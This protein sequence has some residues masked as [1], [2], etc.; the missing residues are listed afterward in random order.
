MARP[1]LFTSKGLP[2][3]LQTPYPQSFPSDWLKTMKAGQIKFYLILTTLFLT[4]GSI[5]LFS[6]SNRFQD[7]KGRRIAK[8]PEGEKAMLRRGGFLLAQADPEAQDNKENPVE[9]APAA[10][11]KAPAKAE[12]P[13]PAAPKAP[14]AEKPQDRS[15]STVAEA[16]LSSGSSGP[17]FSM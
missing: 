15:R 12:A 10:Q 5:P 2:S 14:A 13:A 8:A 7:L 4:S 1:L 17:Y 9:K 16:Q 3:L 11:E 6:Q